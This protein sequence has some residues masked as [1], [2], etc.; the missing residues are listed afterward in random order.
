M[1]RG[2]FY[3][4]RSSES[5]GAHGKQPAWRPF[6]TSTKLCPGIGKSRAQAALSYVLSR[7]PV[8]A[9]QLYEVPSWCTHQSAYGDRVPL[10]GCRCHCR[11]PH[12]CTL[13]T[14]TCLCHKW[15]RTGGPVQLPSC[16]LASTCRL[17]EERTRHGGRPG[18]ARR[19][20]SPWPHP[21]FDSSTN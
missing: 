11:C 10:P 18:R 19:S 14:G 8:E 12:N 16:L 21:S 1:E 20:R 13:V 4:H 9:G 6:R 17:R 7:G 3:P 5:V 15:L 2:S